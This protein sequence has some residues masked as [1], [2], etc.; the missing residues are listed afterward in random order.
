MRLC[1]VELR[2]QQV[3]WALLVALLPTLLFFGH[4]PDIQFSI[5]GS[6]LTFT[7]PFVAHGHDDGTSGEDGHEQHCHANVSSCTDIPFTGV[8]A[9]ALLSESV[10]CIGAA[11]AFIGLECAWWQP[12][13]ETALSPELQ[14]P[15]TASSST[16][17]AP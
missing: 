13:T 14:P 9:F 3:S 2:Y 12:A 6:A 17:F 10:A 15:R 11:G 16:L 7:V 1:G 4:W 8:S 5:P